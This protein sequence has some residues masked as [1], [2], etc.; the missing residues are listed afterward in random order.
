MSHRHQQRTRNR[1]L[2]MET[3]EGRRLLITGVPVPDVPTQNFA[4][5]EDVNNDGVV[6][7]G[8]A[9]RVINRLNDPDQSNS[10]NAFSVDVDGDGVVSPRDALLIINRL[11]ER[12]DTS[13]VPPEQR[14]VGLRKALD[15]GQLPPNMSSSQAQELL[16]TLENGGHYEVG[17]RFRNGEMINI[18][19]P[20]GD[21]SDSGI[22]AE[23]ESLTATL[24]SPG[25]SNE[26]PLLETTSAESEDDSDPFALLESA[27]EALTELLHDS[28]L[29]R[30]FAEAGDGDQLEFVDRFASRISEQL[31][32]ADA[33]ERVAQAIAEAFQ[34]GDAAVEDI[35][36]ELQALRATLGETHSQISQ[37]FANLDVEGIIERLGVDLGTLAEAALSQRT[38]EATHEG[39]SL[40]EFLGRQ[41]LRNLGGILP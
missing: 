3:L 40:V 4:N 29:W 25:V 10:P 34:N 23:G 9:L 35:I 39:A 16:E 21:L 36:N 27:D 41:Y 7:P 26:N 12:R 28:T 13:S 17:E 2:S 30:S 19:N 33:R 14:A 38:T 22:A 31:Q 15:G 32:N 18:N 8:D 5:P 1:T 24:Q 20:H 11:N 6:S 37:L